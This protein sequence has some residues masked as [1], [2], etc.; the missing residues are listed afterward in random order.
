MRAQVRQLVAFRRCP[1]ACLSRALILK[2]QFVLTNLEEV[3]YIGGAAIWGFT[4][5][6]LP[7]LRAAV[8]CDTL[9]MRFL[10]RVAMVCHIPG[11]L[12]MMS[13]TGF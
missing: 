2:A 12:V 5:S 6:I 7:G 3:G 9:G 10:V 4:L 8:Q 13:V 11:V 1:G